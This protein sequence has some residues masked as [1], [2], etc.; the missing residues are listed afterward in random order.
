MKVFPPPQ[1]KLDWDSGFCV[2]PSMAEKQLHV[3]SASFFFVK[4][5][6]CVLTLDLLTPHLACFLILVFIL[7]QLGI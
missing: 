6:Q 4:G 1:T 2:E 5:H 7:L 3:Y